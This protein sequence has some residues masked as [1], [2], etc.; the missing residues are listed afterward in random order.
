M[1]DSM[2]SLV[3]CFIHS[4]SS[5]CVSI[6]VSQFLPSSCFPPWCSLCLCLYFWFSN[7]IIYTI[8]S[9]DSSDGKETACSIGGQ[10]SI[11]GLG[12]SPRDGKGHPLQYSGLE[13]SMDTPRG[14]K[15]LDMT[16]RLSL[17]FTFQRNWF[18]DNFVFY[19]RHLK[20]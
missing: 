12:R 16:E 18:P 2:F 1:L 11:P 6:P 14:C 3:I 4:I 17:H 15:E 9:S 20:A 13:N 7:R 19:L 10:S 5:V 8:F